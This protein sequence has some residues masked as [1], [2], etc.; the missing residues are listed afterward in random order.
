[1]QGLQLLLQLGN[2]LVLLLPARVRLF[3]T[4]FLL[5]NFLL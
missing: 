3:S 1:M 2:G 5:R 4:G